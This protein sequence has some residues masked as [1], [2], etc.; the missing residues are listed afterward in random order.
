MAG[1][2]SENKKDKNTTQNQTGKTNNGE[3]KNST[4]KDAG[5][6]IVGASSE[7]FDKI[8]I[9]TGLRSNSNAETNLRK[10]N[11]EFYNEKWFQGK[12]FNN[13][14][15]MR[16]YGPLDERV[17]FHAEM[18]HTSDDTDKNW[19]MRIG[20]GGQIYSY[21]MGGLARKY[22]DSANRGEVMPPQMRASGDWV[23]DT[24]TLT[25]C[26]YP[27][28]NKRLDPK[29]GLIG[30]IG[31]TGTDSTAGYIHQAGVY[32][33]KDAEIL[34]DQSGER[35]FYSPCLGEYWDP[36]T[37][38]Y[39][40]VNWGQMA[41][42]PSVWQSN[43]L[44]Y[45]RYRDIGDGVVEI[46]YASANFGD[47]PFSDLSSPWGGVRRSAL[48][49]FV[50]SKPDGSYKQV[51]GRNDPWE[52]CQFNQTVTARSTGGW[53]ANTKDAGNPEAYALGWVLGKDPEVEGLT[54]EEKSLLDWDQE[55]ISYG[56]A[57][58]FMH[59]SQRD[60]DDANIKLLG[61]P[62]EY[63]VVANAYRYIIRPGD[64][65]YSTFY[66]VN[67]K[68]KDV[69]AK[70]NELSDKVRVGYLK[71][72]QK[73]ADLIPL[74]WKKLGNQKVLDNEGDGKPACYVYAQPALGTR[75]LYLLRDTQENK[76]VITT[77]PYILSG[78]VN[79]IYK[80]MP[81]YRPYDGRVEYVKILGFVVGSVESDAGDLK[82]NLLE[83]VVQDIT[84]F[85]GNGNGDR[86]VRV[87]VK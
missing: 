51:A 81:A 31:N 1:C 70:C 30:H 60:E 84:L 46:T 29:Y 13:V 22:P 17:V 79:S 58:K 41:H 8:F 82:Y 25:W 19:V 44:I 10:E 83:D 34:K 66:L 15:K 40:M 9:D 72:E 55:L 65:V 28:I 7:I 3:T 77:D 62:R 23:D 57:D 32:I 67:G 85:P 36:E 4:A 50:L 76:Y 75:P 35:Q 73:N 64:V 52:K 33:S 38:S 18:S 5:N 49:D 45:T 42:I 47:F 63:N 24:L 6:A 2:N 53:I 16:L 59:S 78:Q 27:E 56:W 61:Q 37:R 86:G 43:M 71:M 26:A 39:Y 11:V 14:G 12:W 20:K 74:Y 54:K 21:V 80:N 68:L 69:A 87:G 48:P